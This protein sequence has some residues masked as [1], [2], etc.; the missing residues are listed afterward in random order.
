MR[1]SEDIISKTHS[2]SRHKAPCASLADTV[3]KRFPR[4][5]HQRAASPFPAKYGH[6]SPAC[7]Q[8]NEVP[9]GSKSQESAFK[10][11][12]FLFINPINLNLRLVLAV[13]W[14]NKN[15]PASGTPI[16]MPRRRVI[17]CSK[18]QHPVVRL[19]LL[20]WRRLARPCGGSRLA[21]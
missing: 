16:E 1:K 21:H 5:H 20:G 18:R 11:T 10:D 4:A 9:Q 7:L 3:L 13:P 19:A 14:L 17:R 2:D 12:D 15:S 6:P 8:L